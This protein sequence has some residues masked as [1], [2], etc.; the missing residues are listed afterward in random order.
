MAPRAAKKIIPLQLPEFKP[1]VSY[2]GVY[3]IQWIIPKNS[4]HREQ[5]IRLMKYIARPLVADQWVRYAKSPTGVKNTIVSTKMGLDPYETFDYTISTSFGN[6]KLPW[7]TS[8]NWFL[9]SKN[10][11][12]GL[13]FQQLLY[14]QITA[15]DFLKNIK[16]QLK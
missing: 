5:A 16:S 12:I 10:Q 13:N 14:G 1:A 6:S 8:T 4:P 15:Q 3:A 11:N 7:A 9:G 2:P